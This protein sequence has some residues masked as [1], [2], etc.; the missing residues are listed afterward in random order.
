MTR[1][2]NFVR[3]PKITDISGNLYDRSIILSI[4]NRLTCFGVI[5]EKL[6]E[7][8]KI[9][10]KSNLGK[11]HKKYKLLLKKRDE[12]YEIFEEKFQ[13]ILDR[14]N[15]LN[16]NKHINYLGNKKIFTIKE[17]YTKEQKIWFQ[18][19]KIAYEKAEAKYNKIDEECDLFIKKHD[20]VFD[21]DN[22]N[23][24]LWTEVVFFKFIKIINKNK[25]LVEVSP[26]FY[27]NNLN[28]GLKVGDQITINPLDI[29]YVNPIDHILEKYRKTNFTAIHKKLD[30]I[31]NCDGIT[32]KNIDRVINLLKTGD[33]VR[34]SIEVEDNDYEDDI[35]Y[36][37]Y[38]IKIICFDI[39]K[40]WFLGQSLWTN[41]QIKY[42]YEDNVKDGC[43]YYFHRSSICN[44]DSNFNKNKVLIEKELTG[45]HYSISKHKKSNSNSNFKVDIMDILP[46]FIVK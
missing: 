23:D 40:E 32:Y 13:Y 4:I 21:N 45:H 26:Y 30:F 31:T 8:R 43:L 38:F 14:Y 7:K 19:Q 6:I 10:Y 17:H 29:S 20:K 16:P 1:L 44:I 46:K 25:Y 39:N 36:D 33:T 28:S 22:D 3:K 42:D 9:D 15:E 18:E 24:E 41:S 27:S 37:N 2:F 11:I 12:E 5:I 34:V 35:V